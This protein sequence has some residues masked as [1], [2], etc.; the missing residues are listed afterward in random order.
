M[1]K[2]ALNKISPPI[3]SSNCTPTYSWRHSKLPMV[4][5]AALTNVSVQLVSDLPICTLFIYP[6]S[7]PTMAHSS[8]GT[9]SA[10]SQKVPLPP[11]LKKCFCSY[12]SGAIPTTLTT[13][14]AS[15][16]FLTYTEHRRHG[17]HNMLCIHNM[18][19]HTFVQQ[20][21]VKIFMYMRFVREN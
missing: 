9:G 14:Y 2:M 21:A 4:Q 15:P 20:C 3:H 13:N 18:L 12:K 16:Q 10:C 8:G 7:T 6:T 5:W 19:L 1:A 17:I 11:P